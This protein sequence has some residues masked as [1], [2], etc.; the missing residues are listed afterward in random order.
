MIFSCLFAVV[1][2]M[3]EKRQMLNDPTV[4]W[5]STENVSKIHFHFYFRDLQSGL[6]AGK[7]SNSLWIFEQETQNLL[8]KKKNPTAQVLPVRIANQM[9][10]TESLRSQNHHIQAK[11]PNPIPLMLFSPNPMERN[12]SIHQPSQMSRFHNKDLFNSKIIQ[13]WFKN[14]EFS[15]FPFYTTL[16]MSKNW[17]IWKSNK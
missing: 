14:S 13:K 2:F 11:K 16:K 4:S 8:K 10:I 3:W 5:K 7:S 17:P 6:N 9:I 15:E 12:I 1:E